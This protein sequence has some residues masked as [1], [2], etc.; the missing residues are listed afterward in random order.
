MRWGIVV[1][2]LVGVLLLVVA[3]GT[4]RAARA[5]QGTAG[6]LYI[7]AYQCP[8]ADS[9]IPSACIYAEGV[10]VVI[11]QGDVVTGPVTTSV[12]GE[13][14]VDVQVGSTVT[15]SIVPGTGP[16][17]RVA[18]ANA[19]T[20]DAV[21]DGA[22]VVFIF[23]PAAGG[24]GGNTGGDGT[25]TGGDPG[26]GTDGGGGGGEEPTSPPVDTT[27]PGDDSD[28]V[29]PGDAEPDGSDEVTGVTAALPRSTGADGPVTVAA[30]PNT[31]T[32]PERGA[33]TRTPV[34]V[35]AWLA[36]ALL[37]SGAVLQRRWD[38]RG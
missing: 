25:D 36:I 6:Q 3:F 27:D 20:I 26:G 33:R 31:G 9:A 17:G 2:R 29:V 35:L 8:T 18:V 21:T 15:A 22:S 24:D 32:G 1:G 7:D 30:L 4:P 5:L 11:T 12:A 13:L 14:S 23:V 10:G 34:D 19:Y 37:G 38:V 16:E 28:T